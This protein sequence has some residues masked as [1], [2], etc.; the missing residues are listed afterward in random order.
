MFV[1]VRKKKNKCSLAG[2]LII[3]LKVV[4]TTSYILKPAKKSKG[5]K[6]SFSKASQI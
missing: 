4:R 6:F 1:I 3:P 2:H 5:Y